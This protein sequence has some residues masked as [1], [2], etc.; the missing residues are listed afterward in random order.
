MKEKGSL[1]MNLPPREP[2]ST[3]IALI[4]GLKNILSEINHETKAK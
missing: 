2:L 4:S 1:G 3:P